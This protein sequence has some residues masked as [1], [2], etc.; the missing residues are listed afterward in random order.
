MPRPFRFGVSLID[1]A[2]AEE[3][4]A[5]CRRAE[6]LG[7]DVILVPD[8]LSML[9]P[10]PA[11]VA[12]AG[13]TERPRLGTFVPTRVSGTRCCWHVRWGRPPR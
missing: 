8:H 10:F 2:S 5:R 1:P 6:E 11:L 3:W 12:A 13:V 4:R 9:A 7:Y